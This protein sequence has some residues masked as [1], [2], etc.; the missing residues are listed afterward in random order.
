[1]K[2]YPKY[3]EIDGRQHKINTDYKVALACFRAMND[4]EITDIER[5]YAVLGLLFGEEVEIENVEKAIEVARKFLQCGKEEIQED[6]IADMDFEYD[7]DLINASFMADYHIDLE[8]TDMHWWKFCSLVSG[9]SD[10][11]ILNKVRDIRNFDVSEIKD[12]KT[13]QK[14][15]RQKQRS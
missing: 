4:A 10:Q 2:V 15:V 9:L 12:T 3:A 1:M 7:E 14:I 13:R 8:N 6:S 5:P 11:T